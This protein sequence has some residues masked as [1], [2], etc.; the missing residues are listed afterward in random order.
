MSACLRLTPAQRL[1]MRG[2]V[3]ESG[4]TLDRLGLESRGPLFVA[5][6][7]AGFAL[8]DMKQQHVE[9]AGPGL[10]A[11]EA[12]PSSGKL[13]L[14]VVHL[15]LE[16]LVLG[17]F[18]GARQGKASCFGTG[19]LRWGSRRQVAQARSKISKALKLTQ[20]LL[21]EVAVGLGQELLKRWSA[22]DRLQRYG[23][24]IHLCTEEAVAVQLRR[25]QS[26]VALLLQHAALRGRLH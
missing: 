25:I 21:L 13:L 6:S 12:L 10:R 8:P 17:L 14:Q 4:P 20:L 24:H 16:L 11:T 7:S 19:R 2:K 1:D 23:L 3:E 15:L 18:S 22:Q 26:A 5:G 9:A